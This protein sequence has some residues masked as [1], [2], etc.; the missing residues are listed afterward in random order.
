M[1]SRS[2]D[3]RSSPHLTKNLVAPPYVA[4]MRANI[5]P[6]RAGLPCCSISHVN[7][8]CE[9]LISLFFVVKSRFDTPVFLPRVRH[10]NVIND[11]LKQPLKTLIS[12]I[13][14]RLMRARR[15]NQLIR[16]R[17]QHHRCHD[18]PFRAFARRLEFPPQFCAVVVHHG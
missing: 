13:S 4:G 1:S 12:Q 7:Q 5:P 10:G 16:N 18:F 11:S 15:A 3:C 14:V 8:E 6:H 2:I 17:E 9:I